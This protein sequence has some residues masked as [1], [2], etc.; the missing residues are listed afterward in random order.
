MVM[1]KKLITVK[2]SSQFNNF[3]MEEALK[4]AQLALDNNEI[5][6]GAVIVNRVSNKVI[7]KTHNIVEQVNNP[8]LH[9][10]IVAIN[11][12][13][14]ILASKNLSDCD[15]YVT[16]EPC[17]MCSAA[18]SFARM[19]RLFYAANDPKQ[20]AVENGGRFFNSKSC[21]YRPEIYSGFSAKFSENLI[22]KFFK[23][24]RYKKCHS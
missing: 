7:A 16:L 9:A 18:I 5:P 2:T 21:F 13:C 4:Q 20:G 12:S 22:R 14:Q 3:F 6:V 10:E 11:Q 24:I 15:M 23:K 17:A 19:G 1:K 8:I